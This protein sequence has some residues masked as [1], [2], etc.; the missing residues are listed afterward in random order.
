MEGLSPLAAQVHHLVELLDALPGVV[1]ERASRDAVD[2]ASA[3]TIRAACASD[4]AR[5]EAFETLRGAWPRGERAGVVHV[6]L[7]VRGAG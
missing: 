3:W 5:V 1:V 4:G 2:L 6:R 7:E